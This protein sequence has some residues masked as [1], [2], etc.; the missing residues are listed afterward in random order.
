MLVVSRKRNER[1]M[2]G[3]QI[4]VTVVEVRGD[5]VRLGVDAPKEVPV[6]REEVYEAIRRN[7]AEGLPADDPAVD[8]AAA[9]GTLGELETYRDLAQNYP[10]EEIA[11][12]PR[13]ARGTP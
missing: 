2:I 1:L 3:A 8:Q 10:G 12:R 4:V 6:H 9:V 11:T 13:H 7:V 5:K